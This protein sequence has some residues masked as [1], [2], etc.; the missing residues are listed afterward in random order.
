MLCDAVCFVVH[1]VLCIAMC[2]AVFSCVVVCPPFCL[3]C[4]FVFCCSVAFCFRVAVVRCCSV[5]RRVVRVR[6]VLCGVAMC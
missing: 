3:V 2:W 5:L 6:G 4:H 1:L